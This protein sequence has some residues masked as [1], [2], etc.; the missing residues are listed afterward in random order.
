MKSMSFFIK[1]TVIF[2][3]K[4]NL[5]H[6]KFTNDFPS[7]N[8]LIIN[9]TETIGRIHIIRFITIREIAKDPLLAINVV[10]N[11]LSLEGNENFYSIRSYF[12]N[13][14]DYIVKAYPHLTITQLSIDGMAKCPYIIIKLEN[15]LVDGIDKK[16]STLWF[17]IR[18]NDRITY[19]CYIFKGKKLDSKI[20][21]SYVK[22]LKSFEVI[23]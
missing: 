14:T 22:Y 12:D 11:K 1:D 3:Y 20:E 4:K 2:K 15:H 17:G 8:T 5:K 6:F 16:V 10:E 19:L 21:E 9:D 23:E 7:K 13:Y 18:V